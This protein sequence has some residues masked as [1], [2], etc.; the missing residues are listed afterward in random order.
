MSDT[1]KAISAK[2]K[3][4]TDVEHVR[5]RPATY[6][7]SAVPTT[8][9][10][11]LIEDGK[12][13]ERS[14]SYIPAFLKMFDEVITNCVDHSKRP[15]GKHL[16]EIDVVIS[17]MLGTISVRDNGG[18]PVIQH[19]EIE[20]NP[21][22]PD[23]IFSSLRSGSNYDDSEERTG[24]GMNG[25]GSKLTNIFSREFKVETCDGVK[26]FSRMHREG[27]TIHDPVSLG[28]GSNRGTTI[29]YTPDYDYFKLEGMDKDH[30]LLLQ[31]RVYEIAACNP[32]IRV[33]LNGKVVELKG[34]QKF[35]SLFTDT[36]VYMEDGTWKIALGLSEDG[37]KHRSYVNTTS[38]MIGGTH[39]EYVSDKIVEQ[40]REHIQK[41]T[42]Q[43]IKPAEIKS[44]FLLFID[45]TV[46]NPTYDSQTKENL[47][48]PVREFGSSFTPTSKFVKDLIKSPVVSE[49]IAWAERKKALDDAREAAKTQDDNAKKSLR[50]IVKYEPATSKDRSEC[51]L[52]LCEGD[53]ALNPLLNVRDPKRH[54]IYPLQ[55]K[56]MNARGKTAKMLLANKEFAELCQIL[57]LRVGVKAKV[58][59]LRY[60]RLAITTDADHDGWHIFGL[61]QNMFK[62]LW[63]E[64][65]DADFIFKL[66]TPIKRAKAGKKSFDFFELHEY[67]T[68]A[69]ANPGLKHEVQ[70]LKGLGGNSNA[71]FKRYMFEPEF[72]EKMTAKTPEDLEAVD[73]MFDP[74]RADD[75][76][77]WLYGNPGSA[78]QV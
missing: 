41:K 24:A 53:S 54:G 52:F 26:M 34:L 10:T 65:L 5:L 29:T 64:L 8:I 27:N 59:E 73:L 35:A 62:V 28:M 9:D 21:W 32:N 60:R 43:V 40:I 63:P 72:L 7:G 39:V 74:A 78:D 14:V 66:R 70:Y 12:A 48:T 56:P 25:L 69:A 77:E 76:K 3:Q 30:E 68:W 49:I 33:T 44:H 19:T 51:I 46:I 20:G 47:V 36:S 45:C 18:I 58:E 16:N 55:G 71:D 23:I 1:N 75:R 22:I 11:W 4:L 13:V 2:Y 50:H 57:G 31:R 67:D 37:F 17:P 15:E 38:T 42:K 61:V 6:A